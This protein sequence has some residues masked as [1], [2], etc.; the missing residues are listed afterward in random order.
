M[1][2]LKKL[3]FS[4]LKKKLI[5]LFLLMALV[6]LMLAS[7]FSISTMQETIK[8][9]FI[10]TS[11]KEMKKASDT[12]NL[13]FEE[14]A[15][16]S[17]FLASR[18]VVKKADETITTYINKRTKEEL[19]MTPLE[20]GGVEAEI[21][22]FYEDFAKTHK[23]VAYVYL[24]TKDGGYVQWPRGVNSAEYDP[25][26][27][28][29][30]KQAINSQ[31]EVVLT[32]PYHAQLDNTIIVSTVTKIKN[33][34]G[35][36]IG[37][38]GL[39][40]SLDGLTKMINNIQ[41]GKNGYLILTTGQG[42]ILAHPQNPKF[43]FQTI[44]KLNIKALNNLKNISSDNFFAEMNKQDYL[45][46]IYT[47]QETNWKFISVIPKE[48][49]TAK[50]ETLYWKI[51]ITTLFVALAVVLLAIY[52]GDLVS[53]PII[54]AT[55]FAQEISN[56]NL[57][58]E[59][60]K[61][62]SRDEIG[63]LGQALNNMRNNLRD[64]LDE[65]KAAY[66]QLGAYTEE[67]SQLN[68][69]LEYQ[70][71]HDSLTELP[72]RSKFMKE[73]EAELDE[74]KEGVVM[75]LDLDNFKEI[76]DTLGHIYGDRLLKRLGA[77]LLK[78]SNE[79]FFVARYGG[80]EFLFLL[81]NRTDLESIETQINKIRNSLN[82]AFLIKNNELEIDFSIGITLYPNDAYS[83]NQLITNADA[84]MYRAK[85]NTKKD[86]F[87]YNIK[88]IEKIEERKRIKKILEKALNNNG[89]ELKYQP[90]INLDNGQAEYL[91]ALIRLK[92]YDISPGKFIPIAENSG[93]II[94]IGRW[95]T[96]RVIGKISTDLK[97]GK[98]P[99]KIAINFSVHQLE[100]HNYIRFLKET[101]QKNNVA[102]E[103]IEIE[104]T[105]SILIKKEEE[106]VKFL[107]Q[108]KD[109]GIKLALDDFGTGYSSLN[110]LNYIPLDKV[111]LDKS[112]NDKFLEAKA[113]AMGNLIKLF[114]SFNLPVVAEGIEDKAQ[115]QRLQEKGCD[116]IQGY[117]F[118]RPQKWDEIKEITTINFIE[119]I[120]E[121]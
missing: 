102:P 53:T 90:Q 50:T 119:K 75:L 111:K 103:L 12:L 54:N 20:N 104:I 68:K 72:N 29:F 80:D 31:E 33:N 66:Q 62:E 82:K 34:D 45:F 121:E 107:K 49:L 93:L 98:A 115:Y 19:K 89:F 109:L 110:Y 11:S 37:V 51:I 114:H 64:Y 43:N 60:L 47:D 23:N 83:P 100:D 85:E 28:P 96:K 95:V 1:E 21:Y 97:K 58:V 94:E 74:E 78:L 57:E 9:N 76:N 81:K 56:N 27:R 117:L 70:A 26:E 41:I 7:Y 88:L 18:P 79:E 84:A 48:E 105:E 101:L 35:E 52:I 39:D 10:A 30:Y 120:N 113:S 22:K 5:I 86:Y 91:E 40:V 55:N 118:S 44:D 87:Y 3:L 13:Y 17:K 77:R 16:N 38:Q 99:K 112:L 92:E 14:V 24:G 108:L 63:D 46:N 4:G 36:V 6:P 106:A 42:K 61:I 8:N 2:Q 32:A 69:K 67:I 59:D 25:R 71:E 116:Y 65:V 15:K 73:L